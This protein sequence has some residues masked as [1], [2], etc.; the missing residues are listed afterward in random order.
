M[1]KILSLFLIFVLMF[2]V[3]GCSETELKFAEALKSINSNKS[4]IVSTADI[5]VN[6]E[7]LCEFAADMYSSIDGETFTDSEV[8]SMINEFIEESRLYLDSD[9]NMNIHFDMTGKYD[10]DSM[11]Y[12]MD[13][14]MSYNNY[15][16]DLGSMY[17]R[18]NDVYIS[19]QILVTMEQLSALMSYDS[20]MNDDY[21]SVA[22]CCAARIV[23][24]DKIFGNKDY[25]VMNYEDYVN[26][27]NKFYQQYFGMM[28]LTFSSNPV[29]N[30]ETINKDY[31]NDIDSFTNYLSEYEAGF[32]KEIENG[33]RFEINESNFDALF[34][35]FIKYANDNPQKASEYVNS[36]KDPTLKNQINFIY[37]LHS[38]DG[39]EE[40][41][42]YYELSEDTANMD[43][44]NKEIISEEDTDINAAEPINE[45]IDITNS[46][47]ENITPE[48][49]KVVCEVYDTSDIKQ[50]FDEFK[51]MFNN[52]NSDLVLRYDIVNKSENTKSVFC[53]INLNNK[54]NN[55]I[56]IK[57]EAD[58]TYKDDIKFENL[59]KDMAVDLLKAEKAGRNAAVEYEID[60]HKYDE[61]YCK[62][63]EYYYCPY[64]DSY[65]RGWYNYECDKCGNDHII[66]EYDYMCDK[67]PGCT[68]SCPKHGDKYYGE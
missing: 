9:R 43:T 1:K 47:N 62:N 29:T 41:E 22:D 39:E 32:F 7:I 37:S 56:S 4:E 51:L 20:Y 24:Y 49:I 67:Q 35:S 18:G 12:D 63:C 68:Y 57:S 8:K 23:A 25:A 53:N 21:Y 26:E 31:T 38:N 40:T 11:Y 10:P 46:S 33:V 36:L 27:Y 3:T 42:V 2:S 19:K 44:D 66:Y 50:S 64:C 59:T 28:E 65:Y 45:I 30:L 16:V 13:M 14:K 34:D 6:T 55:C 48:K 5:S 15:S 58:Y 52:A 60:S 61:D 54:G 17:V